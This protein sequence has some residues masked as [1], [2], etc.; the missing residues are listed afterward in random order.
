MWRVSN[1]T[2]RTLHNRLLKHVLHS[3]L[4]YASVM[5]ILW[6]SLSQ[7]TQQNR[8]MFVCDGEMLDD[9]AGI[10]HRDALCGL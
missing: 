7:V 10:K 6:N 9:K 5:C 3:R 2:Y 4:T 8:M 1:L